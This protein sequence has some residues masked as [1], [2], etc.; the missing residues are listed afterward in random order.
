MTGQPD[1]AADAVGENEYAVLLAG[2]SWFS[3]TFDVM[4]RNLLRDCTYGDASDYLVA[5]LESVGAT[6]DVMPT[7]VVVDAFPRTRDELDV[8][9]LVLLSDVGADSLQI[10][11]QVAAG[12]PDVDRCALLADYVA[13]GG[14]LGML[15]GYL[16]F[17]GKGGMA[18]YGQTSLADVL[19]VEIQRG[20][21]RV[22]TP[23][24]PRPRSTEDLPAA[25]PDEWPA[26]L[27][28]NRLVADGGAT[29]WATVDDDPL[30][31]VGDHG[32]GS[33]FAFA[34][35]CAPHWAPQSFLEWESLPTLWAAIL[36]RVV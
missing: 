3:L 21:D 9:D 18:R 29:V 2:E 16:S 17:A 23:T 14:A 34:T 11:P 27:G 12:E 33:A 15:G 31:V 6:V 35:D 8:Y 30:L 36:D 22:E 26:I 25:I 32:D 5:V 10:T 1:D 28:Y 19:P 4:G 13:D 7:H 24:G 20:D